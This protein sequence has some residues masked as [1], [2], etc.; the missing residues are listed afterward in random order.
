[1]RLLGSV[2]VAPRPDVPG[3]PVTGQRARLAIAR[4]A[5][6]GG[7]VTSEQLA[8]A[9]WGDRLPPTWR[10]AL[11]GLVL[12]LR[13]AFD[14]HPTGPV[15]GAIRTTATGYQLDPAATVDARQIVDHARRAAA[16][17]ARGDTATAL[18]LG[19]EAPDRPP[20]LLPDDDATW[21][22]PHRSA[23]HQ[24]YVELLLVLSASATTTGDANRAIVAARDAVAADPV[25]ERAHRALVEALAAAGDRAGSVTAF[26][27]CRATLATRLGVD[28][29]QETVD[30][31]LTALGAEPA[32]D[33]A[34]VPRW[35]TSFVGRPDELA[36]LQRMLT[37]PGLVTVVGTGGIGKSRLAAEAARA[38]ARGG[39]HAYRW[40][41]LGGLV[42]DELVMAVVAT[43]LG[44]RSDL[45]DPTDVVATAL[46]PL[47][48]AWLILDGCEGVRDGVASLVD[49]LLPRC[50]LLTV[51]ATA[52][53]PLAIEGERLLELAP[54]PPVPGG[55]EPDIDHSPQLQLLRD[56]VG[57]A[58]QPQL[59]TTGH[60]AYVVEVA[61]RCRGIP[62]AL[63]LAAA[64]LATMSVPDLLDQLD[65]ARGG[66]GDQL[67]IMARAAYE[68]L[69]QDE[70]LVFRH[71]G[72]MTGPVTLAFARDVTA[73]AGVPP[74]RVARILGE[75]ANRGLL[76]ID[77][78]PIR[79][80]YTVDDDLCRFAEH[81]MDER[82]E[83]APGSL[84][85]LSAVLSWL[86]D[87]PGAA[88]DTYQQQ[89]SE[90]MPTLR[91]VLAVGV[92]GET[93]VEVCLELAFRLHRFWAVAGVTE[94][95][96]WLA[97]LVDT[98]QPGQASR[99]GPYARWALGYLC[100]WLG[101]TELAI[102]QFEMSVKQLQ[103]NADP[104]R[105]RGLMYLGGLLDDVDRGAEGVLHV[106]EAIDAAKHLDPALQTAVAMGLG[107]ILSERSDPEAAVH[108]RAAIDLAA[109]P[110]SHVAPDRLAAALATAGMICW[111]VGALT[112]A[113]EF[114]DRAGDLLDGQQRIATVVCL[115]AG[116][117]VALSRGD[118]E[119]ALD[120]A[121]RGDTL[122]TRLGV[123]R[124]LPLVRIL[125][126]RTLLLR[127]D[128][129]AAGTASMS[130]LAAA[131]QLPHLHP[132]AGA[133]E[134][135]A[136]V[137]EAAGGASDV[138][139]S[140]L[141]AASRSIR[142]GGDRPIPPT[143]RPPIERLAR[144]VAPAASSIVPSP[145]EA[146]QKATALLRACFS[147]GGMT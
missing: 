9:V 69:S 102:A 128:L 125:L 79:W 43:E 71:L 100:Y 5:L 18:Q 19:G 126:A 98:L 65:R 25:N 124:E 21:L 86:P 142:R 31:Y 141:L 47:G 136:L 76:G 112:D 80:R 81:L 33:A 51:L 144:N 131:A 140:S 39:D 122:G 116:A 12:S 106:R 94:G 46:S 103:G 110:S 54:L 75:L 123:E 48:R 37:R 143:L 139:L 113:Q 22:A 66:P 145:Q 89:V 73:R 115:A 134:T 138:E 40:I 4:L 90:V 63:E 26:E 84:H 52:R 108:A 49:A 14:Q 92:A 13:T 10:A 62:L 101:E 64:S 88:P 96:Y 3:T 119:R 59:W 67:W 42:E 57:N 97:R 120:S 77:R 28:P 58:G 137:L 147:Q 44:I 32:H 109:D 36:R 146:A 87:D 41:V 70:A 133:L 85:V 11:R 105:S 104:F 53:Y 99:W 111:Q 91:K 74:V 7:P 38:N 129:P 95:R 68:L 107:A 72:L 35:G 29:S 118:L 1:M 78:G 121:T 20:D 34:R 93:D 6:D 130:A 8:H 16:A 135:A 30:S 61:Q 82:G 132:L 55:D 114:L 27:Q 15:G 127:G 17:R 117:G 60:T 2:E 23:L 50:P 24:A 45:A 83:R 56:R